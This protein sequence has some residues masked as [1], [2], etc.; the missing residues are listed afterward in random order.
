MSE[1]A[2]YPITIAWSDEDRLYIATAP[3]L[4]GCRTHGATRTEAL[5]KCVPLVEEWLGLAREQGWAIPDARTFDA[6]L[7]PQVAPVGAWTD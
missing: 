1:A 2:R 6:Q 7:S 5:T 4:P 3:D